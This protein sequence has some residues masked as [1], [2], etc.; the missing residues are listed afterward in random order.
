MKHLLS[1]TH[2][3]MV[4]HLEQWSCGQWTAYLNKNHAFNTEA[5]AA[6]TEDTLNDIKRQLSQSVTRVNP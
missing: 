3:S 1:P 5:G 6:F 4:E 2:Q